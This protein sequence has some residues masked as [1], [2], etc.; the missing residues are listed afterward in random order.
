LQAESID[1]Y[2]LH[3]DDPQRPVADILETLNSQVTQGKIRYFGCSNRRL[4]RIE[5]AMRYAAEHGLAGFVGNQCMW[6]YAVPNRDAIEALPQKRETSMVSDAIPFA[7]SNE[8]ASTAS[9]HIPSV[10]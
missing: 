1:L 3:R 2:W 10:H 9:L 5:E 4:E 6:S 7:S 8:F